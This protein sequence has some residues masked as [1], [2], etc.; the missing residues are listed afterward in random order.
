MFSFISGHVTA[1]RPCWTCRLNGYM[2]PPGGGVVGGA[3]FPALSF[4][5]LTAL[6]SEAQQRKEERDMEKGAQ[7]L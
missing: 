2:S 4:M 6:S 3:A 5:L 7:E 1:L